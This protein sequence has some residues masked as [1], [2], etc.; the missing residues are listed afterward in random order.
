MILKKFLL[1]KFVEEPSLI[2]ELLEIDNCVQYTDLTYERLFTKLSE[3]ESNQVSNLVCDAITDG[4]VDSVFKVLINFP[5][6]RNIYVSKSFLAI[7]KYLVSRINEYYNYEKVFL[8]IDDNYNK[9]INS[10]LPI[11]VNGFDEFVGDVTSQ[12]KKEKLIVLE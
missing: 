1:E 5:N 9:Y 12:I 3:V 11:V 6:V 2:K 7:N 4:E 10:E 8:D